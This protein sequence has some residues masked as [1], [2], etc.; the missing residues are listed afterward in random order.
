M[1]SWLKSTDLCIPAVCPA[2]AGH[3]MYCPADCPCRT[4]Q[5]SELQELKDEMQFIVGTFGMKN[6]F[7]S[8]IR[9]EGASS[10]G[11]ETE[12]SEEATESFSIAL[13][14]TLRQ[15]MQG[16]AGVNLRK[17]SKSLSRE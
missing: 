12:P 8:H 6:I 16:P 1:D 7:N 4:Q 3:G 10:V 2:A 14:W 9:S 11:K 13:R 17:G 5:D 15:P